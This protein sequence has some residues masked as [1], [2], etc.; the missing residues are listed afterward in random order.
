MT[1]KKK[2]VKKDENLEKIVIDELAFIEALRATID[3]LNEQESA[4]EARKSAC[5]KILKNYLFDKEYYNLVYYRKNDM[6]Y[7][8]KKERNKVGYKK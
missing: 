5:A 2:E 8:E 3:Y 4:L 1:T 7:Y 6:V